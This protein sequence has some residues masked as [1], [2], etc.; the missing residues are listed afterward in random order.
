MVVAEDAAYDDCG[1]EEDDEEGH[2]HE[3]PRH[4]SGLVHQLGWAGGRGERER[5]RACES[6]NSVYGGVSLWLM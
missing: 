2:S 1:D 4:R 6:V 3:G 5:V